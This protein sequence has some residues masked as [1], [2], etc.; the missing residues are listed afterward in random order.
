MNGFKHHFRLLLRRAAA[1][2]LGLGIGALSIASAQAFTGGKSEFQAFM[3]LATGSAQHTIGFANGGTPVATASWSHASGGWPTASGSFNL[4][5]PIAGRSLPV[6][7]TQAFT[8]PSMAAALG[9]F[10]SKVIGPITIG[11]AIYDLLQDLRV[12]AAWNDSTQQQ[13]LFQ[14]VDTQI[15]D[16]ATGCYYFGNDVSYHDQTAQG[17]CDYWVTHVWLYGRPYT[18]GLEPFATSNTGLQ[19]VARASVSGG[20]FNAG[21]VLKASVIY[22]NGNLTTGSAENAITEPQV[23]ALIAGKSGWTPGEGNIDQA[24]QDA[25]ASGQKLD[26]DGPAVLT[27]PQGLNVI[28]SPVTTSSS[29]GSSITTTHQCALVQ[30]TSN[31]GWSSSVEWRCWDDVQT[32]TPAKTTTQTVVTSNPDGTTSTQTVT[33]TDPGG[34]VTTT[35]TAQA[36][37][38]VSPDICA[39]DPDILACQKLG[40]PTASDSIDRTTTMVTITPVSF[41]GGSCPQPITFTVMGHTYTVDYATICSKLA[42][43]APLFLTLAGFLAAYIVV[44][45]FR[46]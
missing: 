44:D 37:G 32:V 35:T 23:E 40:T 1:V 4:G 20:G 14:T 28:A 2:A 45:G 6:T 33:K 39:K 5:S 10:A 27:F 26:T 3:D 21:D 12:R 31:N 30:V 11:M 34:T 36:P 43:V 7:A 16:P 13:D 41:A 18:Y 46:V 17:W 9:K 22:R 19:C 25:L 24:L 42:L 29:D 8:K 15:C 38:D